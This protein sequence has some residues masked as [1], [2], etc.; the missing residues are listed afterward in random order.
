MYLARHGQDEDNLR[1][2]LN[3][4]SDKPLT[5]LGEKQA[6]DL[7]IKIANAGLR[8]EKVYTSPLIRA[9]RTAEIITDYLSLPKAEIEGELIE[10]DLGRMNGE[11]VA[12]IPEL[13]GPNIL[14]TEG[15]T[16]Y[17]LGAEGGE[18]FLQL[19]KRA[20]GLLQKIKEKYRD[21]NILLV[22]HDC[23][24][25]MIYA[26]YYDLDWKDVLKM[27]HFGNSDL[28]L[29]APDSPADQAHLFKIKQHNL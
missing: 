9:I 25:K 21:G 16:V 14:R 13:C 1:G 8:F 2:L 22:C 6:K 27:F 10:K 7:A 3:G 23:I 4:R 28:L 12:S 20:D 18:D 5:E 15:G 26:A 19:L 17:F 29:L 24:G 11:L